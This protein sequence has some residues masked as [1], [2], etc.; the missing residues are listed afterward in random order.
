MQGKGGNKRRGSKERLEH[1]FYVHD[2]K[3]MERDNENCNGKG[4]GGHNRNDA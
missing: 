4:Y 2:E 3:A 1:N